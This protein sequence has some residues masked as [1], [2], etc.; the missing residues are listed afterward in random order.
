MQ[1]FDNPTMSNQTLEKMMLNDL[2]IASEY[3][4]WL[5]EKG[6][7]T[8]NALF[9][10]QDGESLSKPG[11]HSWRE[12]IRLNLPHADGI[13]TYYLKRFNNPPSSMK[14]E[15][16]RS[17]CDAASVAGMEWAWLNRVSKDGIPCAK[18]IAMGE[19]MMGSK[20]RRSAILMAAV[21]GKSLET[22]AK[23]WS[24]EIQ[25]ETQH[26]LKL[27]AKLVSDFH[28]L[29]YVHRD[30]YLSHL[31]FDE[32][33]NASP[34]KSLH[35]IDLQRARKPRCCRRRWVVKDLAALNFST[36]SDVISNT[37]RIR[38]LKC[39]LQTSK[40]GA[41]ARRLIYFIVGKTQKMTRHEQRR[42]QRFNNGF[43]HEE[44]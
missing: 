20:E 41:D 19:E 11:L 26:L 12:R 3:E 33:E 43:K 44:R 24:P 22:Y 14:R 4:S 32:D 40:L 42:L 29:G 27:T 16:H 28:G 8:L 13:N 21:P 37:D 7:D 39:Y 2:T 9:D 34:E 1:V 17:G 38:W 35:L 36:P 23:Q 10:I 15:I 18:P 31:F 6:L 30:L 5:R 25:Y